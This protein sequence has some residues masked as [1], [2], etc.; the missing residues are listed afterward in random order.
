MFWW[1][2]SCFIICWLLVHCCTLPVF[3]AA[4]ILVVNKYRSLSFGAHFQLQHTSSGTACLLISVTRLRDQFPPQTKDTLVSPVIA[5]HFAVTIRWQIDFAFVDFEMTVVILTTLEILI[6][7]IDWL[8]YR[9]TFTPFQLEE[10][11]R[12][13]ERAPYPDV[14]ARE[15]LAL[16][17]GLSESRI[18]VRKQNTTYINCLF[19]MYCYVFVREKAMTDINCK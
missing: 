12:A 4:T 1:T 11:E 6:W 10:M 17:I 15:D 19:D 3:N 13:F 14:F 5:R 7:L 18:Q 16:R 2:V 8:T 9:V